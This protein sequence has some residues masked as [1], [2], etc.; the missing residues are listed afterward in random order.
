MA[1]SLSGL[2][3]KYTTEYYHKLID[4][5][6]FNGGCK[7]KNDCWVMEEYAA[8]ANKWAVIILEHCREATAN[9]VFMFLTAILLFV[10]ATLVYVKKRK[11]Y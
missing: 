10:S 5:N 1:I 2:Q 7:G 11:G 9:S 3:C 4:N 8:D 6:L